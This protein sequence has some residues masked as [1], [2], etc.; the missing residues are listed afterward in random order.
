[1]RTTLFL[2]A[3][4]MLAAAV[5]ARATQDNTL[6]TAALTQAPGKSLEAL[7]VSYAPG[8]ASKPH[9][10]DRDA[11]VYVVSGHV[12]SQVEGQPLRVYATG[13][14]WFEPAGARHLVSANA[15][16]TEPATILVVFVGKPQIPHK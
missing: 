13:D 5:T 14:N 7:R 16:S 1:M 10:H 15:S 11:Y 8:E 6:L 3:M 12:R 2:A 4:L 9:S